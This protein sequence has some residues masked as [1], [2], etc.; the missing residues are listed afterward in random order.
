MLDAV[1]LPRD[2]SLVSPLGSLALA[3][4]G[5]LYAAWRFWTAR[6]YRPRYRTGIVTV[7]AGGE[8]CGLVDAR[9]TVENN[10]TH[11]LDVRRV[12]VSAR[13]AV[14]SPAD[15][16][17]VEGPTLRTLHGQEALRVVQ[18]SVERLVGISPILPGE[19]ATFSLRVP[20]AGLPPCFFV[21]GEVEIERVHNPGHPGKFSHLHV[22][23][24]DDG[25]GAGRWQD[26]L[27]D[28]TRVVAETGWGIPESRD[29]L[30]AQ[31]A[32]LAGRFDD[33]HD[34]LARSRPHDELPT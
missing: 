19:S 3:T 5:G 9:Y 23:R 24:A 1:S 15:G 26:A 22:A 20:V 2:F 18:P 14:V 27:L 33:V 16:R 10:G 11:K 4:A 31:P 28:T 25:Q 29:N 17:L 21:V 34:V 8:R 12:A 6:E 30:A 13:L 7:T 32:A